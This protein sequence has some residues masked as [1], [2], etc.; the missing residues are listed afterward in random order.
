MG[1]HRDLHPVGHGGFFRRCGPHGADN[2][3]LAF[4]QC[5][6]DRCE[7]LRVGKRLVTLEVDHGSF[8]S[9][10]VPG[11]LT[12]VRAC[13]VG[14]CGHHGFAACCHDGICNGGV[15]GGHAHP[16]KTGMRHGSAPCAPMIPFEDDATIRCR[17]RRLMMSRQTWTGSGGGAVEC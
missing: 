11:F 7:V 17:G 13:C 15:V 3:P 6:A 8:V 5:G 2:V 12:T 14:V 10:G 9:P 1:V 16:V 4:P